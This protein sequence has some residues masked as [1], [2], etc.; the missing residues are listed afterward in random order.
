MGGVAAM[1]SSGAFFFGQVGGMEKSMAV[2]FLRPIPI[3]ALL[4][5]RAVVIYPYSTAQR[6]RK[7]REEALTERWPFTYSI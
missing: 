6:T 7:I 1:I 4:I 5:S 3:Q 2:S